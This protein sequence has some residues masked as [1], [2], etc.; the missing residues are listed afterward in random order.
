MEI[1]AIQ[2]SKTGDRSDQ[3]LGY[4]DEYR[5]SRDNWGKVQVPQPSVVSMI[6]LTVA[7]SLWT[8][9]LSCGMDPFRKV[10]KSTT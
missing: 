3:T 9:D 2:S 10:G 4:L 1:R 7:Q 6:F 8:L 5:M